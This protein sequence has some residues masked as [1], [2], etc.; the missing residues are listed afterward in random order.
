M[1]GSEVNLHEVLRILGE[2]NISSVLV[3]AGPTLSSQMLRQNLVDKVIYYVAPK[4]LGGDKTVVG[5]I[6]VCILDEAIKLN[7][8]TAYSMGDD[9]VIEGYIKKN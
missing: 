2:N 7:K 6:G 3:E 4:I 9:I 5:D 8:L 1:K